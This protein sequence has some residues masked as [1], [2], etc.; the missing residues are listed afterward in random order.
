MVT[1]HPRGRRGK[2][3]LDGADNSCGNDTEKIS[4]RVKDAR[5][6]WLGVVSVLMMVLPINGVACGMSINAVRNLCE[7][8]NTDDRGTRALGWLSTH[9]CTV[10]TLYKKLRLA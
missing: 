1:R 2:F 5:V 6:P 3:G 8:G 7:T 10:G 4:A 9:S